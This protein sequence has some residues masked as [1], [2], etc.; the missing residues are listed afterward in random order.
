VELPAVDSAQF[1]VPYDALKR[2]RAALV[3]EIEIE[4][5]RIADSESGFAGESSNLGIDRL[6]YRSR[7]ALLIRE[8]QKLVEL[9]DAR[10]DIVSD[11]AR[12]A[13]ADLDRR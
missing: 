9:T 3:A 1:Q 8:L 12:R 11:D 13:G 4:K 7:A 10:M 5:R 2:N 6:G